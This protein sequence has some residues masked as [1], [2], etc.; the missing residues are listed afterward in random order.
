MVIELDLG[1]YDIDEDSN[2]DLVIRDSNGTEVFKY[3]SSSS[4]WQ[5]TNVPLTVGTVD[6]S[7][8]VDGA[9][10]SHTGELEDINHATK[11]EQGGADEI[12]VTGL[13]GDLADE[14]DPKAHAGEHEAGGV[15]ELTIANLLNF[16]PTE[17]IV[18][19]RT[20]QPAAGTADRVMFV[21]DDQV[22]EYDNGTSWV[23]L[24]A[25]RSALAENGA[26]ELQVESMGT[27]STA[28]SDFFG[29]DGSGGVEVRSATGGATTGEKALIYSNLG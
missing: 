10:V 13:S 14:Q 20:N 26:S 2:G 23:E 21:T 11:H 18:D 27:S 12:S 25:S 1:N 7:D 24:G 22:L 3:D 6:V 9:G 19:T 16:D 29:P 4:E 5:I 15:D 17:V 8:L 28:S